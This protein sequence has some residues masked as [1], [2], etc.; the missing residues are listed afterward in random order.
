MAE[1]SIQP[2]AA[3][4]SQSVGKPHMGKRAPLKGANWKS[5]LK[6]AAIQGMSGFT[7]A[8]TLGGR[9][10][11]GALGAI[12]GA[13]RKSDAQAWAGAA[14]NNMG[15]RLAEPWVG[16]AAH[17]VGLTAA[18]GAE[19]VVD[20]AE[21]KHKGLHDNIR[22]HA[23]GENKKA[24]EIPDLPIGDE[25]PAMPI[26]SRPE[27][28]VI[29][30][31]NSENAKGDLPSAHRGWHNPRTAHADARVVAERRLKFDRKMAASNPLDRLSEQGPLKRTKWSQRREMAGNTGRFTNILKQVGL[32][33]PSVHKRS[34]AIRKQRIPKKDYDW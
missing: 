12:R 20:Y 24:F 25:E 9:L 15:Y 30:H 6:R 16:D 19:R 1:A 32:G 2:S 10:L 14:A 11:K 8:Q 17:G 28:K 27:T 31:R 29:A 4:L 18:K 13:T 26:H 3:T 34:R 33:K 23:R 5:R 21:R 22:A 7:S